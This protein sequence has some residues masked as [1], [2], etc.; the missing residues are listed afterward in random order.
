MNFFLKT[1]SIFLYFPLSVFSQSIVELN[2]KLKNYLKEDTTKAITLVQL[3]RAYYMSDPAKTLEYSLQA[4]QLSEKI[5][6]KK[7]LA[8][9]TRFKAIAEYS[10]GNFKDAE[11]SLHK[12]LTTYESINNT[13]G[14]MACLSMLGTVN[15]VQNKYPPALNYYQKVVRFAQKTNDN[16]NLGVAY[17][18]MGVIYS[19][20]KNY[21]QALKYFEDGLAINTKIHSKIGVAGSLANV[22][23][24][25]FQTKDFHNALKFYKNALE[26]NLEIDN[27]LGIAREYGNVA[28][29]NL[30]L[31][32]YADAFK[33]FEKAMEV[34]QIIGNKKG[35]AVNYHGIGK[36]YLETNNLNKALDYTLKA[37]YL[38][39]E[40]KVQ[41]VEK[42]T[43]DNLSLI[44]EKQGR[45]D[46]AYASYKKYIEIKEN[47]DNEANRKQISRLEIQYEFESKEEKYKTEQLLANEKLNQQRLTLALNQANLNKSEKEKELIRLDF[48]KTQSELKTEK[49]EKIANEKQLALTNKEIELKNVAIKI[50][51]IS[52]K[53][54]EKQKLYYLMGISMLGLIGGLLFYQ[55]QSRRKSNQKLQ[56]LNAELDEANKTKAKF[57]AILS[58]DLRSPVSNLI[59]F[60]NL[61]KESP[62]M[63]T[64]E[65]KQRNEQKISES[66]ENLLENMES[67]L[68]WSKSQMMNFEPIFKPVLVADFFKFLAKN[69]KNETDI[70]FEFENKENLTVNTDADYLKTILQN[71]NQN[72]I[73]ALKNKADSTIIWKAKKENNKLIISILDNAAGMQ[74]EAIAKLLGESTE[75]GG[76]S[77]FGLVLVY[78]LAKKI[79]CVIDA[80]VVDNE[81]TEISLKF[82]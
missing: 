22:G 30:E 15:T 45:M 3:A 73:K 18:N 12:S 50:N 80:K 39:K 29:A 11:S 14:I 76:I 61:Q 64:P 33:N 46:S 81:S 43:Y 70:K 74:K 24:V 36:S 4:A 32:N 16:L 9:A 6:F 10:T 42:E 28:N 53:T 23:N 66:A 69:S 57:F 37:N 26:K 56:K 7:G 68:L 41:D 82:E 34:N 65:I 19:E 2:E 79:A 20:L 35:L 5:N 78:D 13:A 72:A 60:L 27:K 17:T 40:V 67:M 75:L 51:E 59:S 21:P 31:K 52:L 1:I 8:D 71:L 62:E 44:Y 38:A 54:S 47:I 58:H 25:Y 77:G 48:L 55:N 49:L 63:I